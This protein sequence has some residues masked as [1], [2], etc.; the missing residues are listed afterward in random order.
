MPFSSNTGRIFS[1]GVANCV[2]G[3]TP[4]K[5]SLSAAGI[6]PASPAVFNGVCGASATIGVAPACAGV[7]GPGP[8]VG[9]SGAAASGAFLPNATPNAP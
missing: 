9:G 3:T 4:P 6:G 8:G 1:A 7:N 5:I 2:P